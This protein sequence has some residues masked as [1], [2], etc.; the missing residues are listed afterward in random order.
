VLKRSI[1]AALS[2]L[3]VG[4][5]LGACAVNPVSKRPE[6]VLVSSEK[7]QEIGREEAV[8]VEQS[9]GLA[10]LATARDYVKK[11]GARVAAHSP[12]Q[13]VTYTFDVVDTPE[14]NAF[15]LPGG[16]VYVSRGLLALANS[17]DE[18]AGVLGHEVGH[19]AARHVVQRLS[20][21][22]PFAVIVGIPSSI[23]GVVS[24]SLGNAIAAPGAAALASHSR[25]QEN[26]ADRLGMD[27]AGAA[28]YDPSALGR[29]L[30]TME[31][32]ELLERE[33][34]GRSHFFD[35]HP[36]TSDRVQNVYKHATKVDRV[37][38]AAI[39]P[40][41]ASTLARLRG[42]L[43]G[44]NPA[45]GVFLDDRFAHPDLGFSF[46]LPEGWKSQ[47]L[48]D[49][50]VALEDVEDKPSFAVLTLAA[51]SDDP[52][53]GARA[54]GLDAA[55]V[56]QMK[57]KPINGLNTARLVTEQKGATLMMTWIAFEGTVYRIACA[58]LTSRWPQ[59]QA[60]FERTSGSFRRLSNTDRGRIREERLELEVALPGERIRDVVARG[61]SVW[62]ADRAAIANQ[63]DGPDSVP[64]SG[65]PMKIAV[66]RPYRGK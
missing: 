30:A 31:R 43:V 42:L 11:I 16:P 51:E 19:I 53:E 66:T 35:S 8:K 10:D 28:G 46:D 65:S 37:T 9:M 41:R 21:T 22:A 48:P 33:D 17:E 62:S 2:A 44:D 59:L 24:K 15:A 32:D 25:G 14:P 61:R 34:R 27:L 38:A 63:L 49:L 60:S 18:I 47:N 52:R 1:G 5:M 58:G 50:V 4:G 36:I 7:E 26:E 13:D 6:M 56:G 20:V 45:V 54:D 64:A 55:L 57:V 40:D 12:R 23:V 29:I 3:A 39:A